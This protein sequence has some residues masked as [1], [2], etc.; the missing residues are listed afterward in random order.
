MRMATRLSR[1]AVTGVTA[2]GKARGTATT[3]TEV[4]HDDTSTTDPYH[5]FAYNSTPYY[6]P[7]V[8]SPSATAQFTLPAVPKSITVYGENRALAPTSTATGASFTDTFGPFEAHV[9][10]IS[11]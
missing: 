4:K 5:L 3:R 1:C 7:G 2:N 6:D 8:A 10:L 11:Y 9:Y